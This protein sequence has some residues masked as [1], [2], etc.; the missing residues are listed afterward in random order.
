MQAKTQTLFTRTIYG[1]FVRFAVASLVVG[2]VAAMLL[3]SAVLALSSPA[4]TSVNSQSGAGAV[5]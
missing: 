2:V 4:P 3:S 5:K 1:D